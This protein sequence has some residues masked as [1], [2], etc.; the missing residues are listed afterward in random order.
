MPAR[1][2]RLNTRADPDGQDDMEA[3]FNYSG[4]EEEDDEENVTESHP[5]NPNPS[6]AI[7][8]RSP[9]PGT[10]DFENADYDYPPPGSPPRPSSVALPNDY[11][12]SN[13]FIPSSEIESRPEPR[14]NWFQR[15]VAAA[16]PVNFVRRM[17][18]GPQRPAGAIGG[19]TN[20]DGV[21]A[22]VTAKPTRPLTIREGIL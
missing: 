3:A 1:Y 10:Y 9:V 13:G 16:L 11:G 7:S 21:F 18:L 15:S 5:L 6:P 22:N 8:P 4:E 2:A 12:N 20:N 17:G 19:G 14:R